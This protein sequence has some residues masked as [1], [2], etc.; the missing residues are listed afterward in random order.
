M[1][2]IQ[3]NATVSQTIQ[4]NATIYVINSMQTNNFCKNGF[5]N[6]NV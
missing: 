6:T 4:F 5:I 1:T 2:M 3:L